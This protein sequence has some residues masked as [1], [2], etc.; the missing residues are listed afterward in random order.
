MPDILRNLPYADNEELAP[1][2]LAGRKIFCLICIP[3]P[4]I[5]HPIFETIP[6]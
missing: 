4:G 1:I 3:A 6:F 2:N 5:V